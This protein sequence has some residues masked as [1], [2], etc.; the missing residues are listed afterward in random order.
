[1]AKQDPYR[2]RSETKHH[3]H[4]TTRHFCHDV[5]TQHN[6]T[7]QHTHTY[8]P[9]QTS[10][11]GS[12]VNSMEARQSWRN[13]WWE[14]EPRAWCRWTL[15]V[16]PNNEHDT[17]LALVLRLSAAGLEAVDTGQSRQA[18]AIALGHLFDIKM[19]AGSERAV[20]RRGRRIFWKET[21]HQTQH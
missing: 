13:K 19:P 15:F 9:S 2:S 7:K 8:S 14:I 5:Y 12:A 17:S 18:I 16:F 20:C 6:A 21:R 3:P 4:A 10:S 1:M 11:A